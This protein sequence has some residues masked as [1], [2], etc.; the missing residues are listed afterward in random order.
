MGRV[1]SRHIAATEDLGCISERELDAAAHWVNAFRA[2]ADTIAVLPNQLLRFC[3]AAAPC[4]CSSPPLVAAW[5][6]HDGVI[7]LAI[8]AARARCFLQRGDR[9]QSL[10]KH[11]KQL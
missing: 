4:A 6:G 3:A 7:L 8:D 2:N 9:Q 1:P 10:H 5:H 11:L